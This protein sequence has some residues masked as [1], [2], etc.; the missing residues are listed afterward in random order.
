MA[1]GRWHPAEEQPIATDTTVRVTPVVPPATCEGLA[2]RNL[3]A[4]ERRA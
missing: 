3:P 1:A 2:A 4:P